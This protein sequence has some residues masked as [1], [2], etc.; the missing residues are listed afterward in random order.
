M[1]EAILREIRSVYPVKDHYLIVEF[2]GGDYRVVDIRPFL[3]G[4]MFEPLKAP[5]FFRQVRVDRYAKTVIWP[6]G[7][8]LD[9]DVLYDMGVSLKLPGEQ[10]VVPGT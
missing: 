4:P 2:N 6:N 5:A 7:A 8:D 10:A 3:K 9:P 1:L